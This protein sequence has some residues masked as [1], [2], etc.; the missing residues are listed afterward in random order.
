L[1]DALDAGRLDVDAFADAFGADAFA[2]VDVEDR[3][4]VDLETGVAADRRARFGLSPPMPGNTAIPFP[5]TV[6][7]T[8]AA[9]P[10]A[11]P[12]ASTTVLATAPT[13]LPTFLSIFPGFIRF[14]PASSR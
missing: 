8:S 11:V 10:A 4:F 2:A 5:T 9:A 3:A 14:P 6:P 7:A 12:A 13:P 1:A